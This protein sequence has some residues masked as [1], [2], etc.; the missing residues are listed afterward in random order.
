MKLSKFPKPAKTFSCFKKFVAL[1]ILL[2]LLMMGVFCLTSIGMESYRFFLQLRRFLPGALAVTIAMYLWQRNHYSIKGLVP[3][4]LI[5]LFW[6][7]TYNVTSFIANKDI[8]SNLNN[9]MDI[10][11]ASYAFAFLVFAKN[12]LSYSKRFHIIIHSLSAL[13]EVCL[14][15]IPIA[16]ILYFCNYGSTITSP[17]AIALLQTNPNEA[18]EYLIQNIGYGG[19]IALILCLAGLLISSY[20]MNSSIV[21]PQKIFVP[22]KSCSLSPVSCS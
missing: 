17:A 11:F 7:I 14:M 6:L 16:S 4:I 1:F 5:F 19:I 22:V 18:K 20:R 15:I 9:Y 21:T 8:T 10:T 3:D 2:W 13:V 12:L